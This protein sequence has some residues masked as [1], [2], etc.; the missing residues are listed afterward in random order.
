[1]AKKKE[2]Y[3]KTFVTSFNTIIMEQPLP[4]GYKIVVEYNRIKDNRWL[5]NYTTTS[6][7]HVCPN[8]GEFKDCKDCPIYQMDDKEKFLEDCKAIHL[9][10]RINDEE[11]VRRVNDCARVSECKVSFFG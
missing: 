11:M 3:N 8:T 9:K 2:R 6:T 1:M 7:F 4:N 10:Q 5:P